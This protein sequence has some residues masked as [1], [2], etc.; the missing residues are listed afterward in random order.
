M[1]TLDGAIRQFKH[2]DDS[3]GFVIAYDKKEIDNIIDKLKSCENCNFAYYDS[4]M[5]LKCKLDDWKCVNSDIRLE[6]WEIY[7]DD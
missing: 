4:S 5:S 2:N 1:K 6:F 3:P 7:E